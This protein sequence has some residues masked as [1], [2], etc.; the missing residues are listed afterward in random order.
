MENTNLNLDFRKENSRAAHEAVKKSKYKA[1][2]LYALKKLGKGNFYQIAETANLEPAQ[3]WK[4]LSEIQEIEPCGKSMGMNG[5]K[6]SDW[7][8][9]G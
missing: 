8:I 1:S 6:V 7:R 3:V 4:R 5:R 9:K 2:I